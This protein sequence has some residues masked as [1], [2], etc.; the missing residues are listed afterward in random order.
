MIW[1]SGGNK[2]RDME[3]GGGGCGAGKNE[4]LPW[5]PKL[6]NW[7]KACCQSGG[8]DASGGS[9]APASSNQHIGHNRWFSV[10]S[11]V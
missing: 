6:A 4:G 7:E 10:L 2:P 5:D 9:L 3:A 1:Y 11:I 8:L